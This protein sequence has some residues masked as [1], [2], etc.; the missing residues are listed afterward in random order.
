MEVNAMAKPIKISEDGL[1]RAHS[2][3]DASNDI[4]G[5]RRAILTIILADNRYSAEE[6]ADRFHISR[7][8]VFEEVAKVRDPNFQPKGQWGGA[9]NNLLTYEEEEA[10][11]AD[12]M[13]KA[14]EGLILSMPE[15]HTLYN[16]RVGKNVAKSTFY[17]MLGRHNWRKVKP[18]TRHPKGKPELQEEFKKKR[19]KFRWK[20]LL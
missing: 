11:L 8:T 16:A 1:Q 9:R 18:D 5:F 17:S 19:S 4:Q 13:D 2:L 15:I 6:L 14:G 3:V 12:F 7:S 10:F 20:K